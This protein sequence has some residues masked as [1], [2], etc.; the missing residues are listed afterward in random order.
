VKRLS[1]TGGSGV[2]AAKRLVAVLGYHKI[3]Q[4]PE[5]WWSWQY[6]P[7]DVFTAQVEW[8]RGDGWEPIAADELI[9]GLDAPERLP[10][11]SFLVT[12]DDAYRSLRDDALDCLRRLDLPAVVFAPTEFVGGWNS[13]DHDIEPRAEICDWAAL[14]ELAQN[15]VAI[16]FHGVTHRSLSTLSLREQERE[17][18]D[19]KRLLEEELGAPV[20]LLA[21]PYGDEGDGE[22]LPGALR[23]AGYE[24][25]FGYGGGAFRLPAEGR[26]ALPRLAMGPDT[27]IGEELAL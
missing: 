1:P 17:A 20:R 15:G 22:N 3:G 24:A 5:E 8:L 10:P 4:P 11:K 26:Y 18:T 25:A 14:R 19:S 13:F 7:G 21:Y 23:A 27:D 9:A 12:F 16:E 6:V 2:P